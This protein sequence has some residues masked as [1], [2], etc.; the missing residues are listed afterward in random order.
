MPWSMVPEPVD[1][2]SVVRSEPP[3]ALLPTTGVRL[4]LLLAQFVGIAVAIM[5]EYSREAEESA[6]WSAVV[7]VYLIVALLLVTWS[8]F[9]MT[10][11][12]RLVPATAYSRASSGFV[13]VLLWLIAFAA[14]VAAARAIES[15]QDRFDSA[16][17]SEGDTT[18]LLVTVVAVLV[19][20]VLV[21]LP[22]RYHTVQAHR[23]GVPGRVV[24]SWFW[25]PVVA[26][27]G[28]LLIGSLGMSETLRDGGL[29]AV[30]RAVQVGV[31]FGLPALVF[32]FATWRATTVFDEVIELRWSK[33][34]REWDQS[35]AAVTP[36]FA[37]SPDS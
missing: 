19:S 14:P 22:F 17:D 2:A 31:L 6:A 23:I 16:L 10:N 9:A 27:V 8:A 13:A 7:P 21:W 1:P 34:A 33:W 30:E 24:S 3:P 5:T 11:A 20:A 32:A 29:T 37:G 25:L 35:L 26:G 15:A 18:I 12:A 28:A 36:R 4:L